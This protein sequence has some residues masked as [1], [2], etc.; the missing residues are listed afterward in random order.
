[1]NL[2]AM[3]RDAFL[4]RRWRGKGPTPNRYAPHQGARE[5]ARRR[6]DLKRKPVL[7]PIEQRMT[8]APFLLSD[9]ILSF[10]DEPARKMVD[11]WRR[12][13]WIQYDKAT[14]K[15]SVTATGRAFFKL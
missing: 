12:K 5:C 4:G 3:I 8:S 6:G 9:L 1:M 11:R 15:W 13:A 2:S 14:R 7:S 10:G